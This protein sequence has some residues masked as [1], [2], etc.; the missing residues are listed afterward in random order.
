MRDL[1]KTFFAL[2]S[3]S[4]SLV[5]NG[6]S[7]WHLCFKGQIRFPDKITK[8][9]TD[10]HLLA[11]NT[12]LDPAEFQSCAKTFKGAETTDCNNLLIRKPLEKR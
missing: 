1:D 11:R 5:E 3:K 7:Y 2:E 6:L 8:I 12:S 4:S 10:D 9:Y